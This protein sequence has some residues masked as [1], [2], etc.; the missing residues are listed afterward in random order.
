MRRIRVFYV[1]VKALLVT[2]VVSLCMGFAGSALAI[3]LMVPQAVEAQSA[4]LRADR[5]VINSATGAD[6]VVLE[7][8]SGPAQG[9]VHLIDVNG[10]P[11]V[12]LE[13]GG[14]DGSNPNL[15]GFHLRAEDG[16]IVGNLGA[17]RDEQGVTLS[18]NDQQG[19]QRIVLLVDGNGTPTMQMLDAEGNVTWSAP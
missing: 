1:Q 15:F 11:R 8:S 19:H 2:A 4:Q 10:K 18:L 13:M 6:R 3:S 17:P 9:A 16:T 7:G 12:G 14:P 5:L